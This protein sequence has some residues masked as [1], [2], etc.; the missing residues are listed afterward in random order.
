MDTHAVQAPALLGSGLRLPARPSSL[1]AARRYSEQA[2]C[3]FG[4]SAE[5]CHEVAYAVNEAVTNAIRHGAPDDWGDITMSVLMDHDRLTIVVRDSGT[6][7]LPSESSANSDH[8]RGLA[9]MAA[10]MDDVRVQVEPGS[11]TI[12]LTKS[13]A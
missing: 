11:T 6:F 7:Q 10:L 8:G 13:R 12:Y 9:L 4:M 3:A 5:C 2:A 1:A